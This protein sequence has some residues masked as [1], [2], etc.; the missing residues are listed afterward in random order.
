MRKLRAP[1]WSDRDYVD[2]RTQREI[3]AL[4]GMR[5]VEKGGEV[6]VKGGLGKRDGDGETEDDAES[7]KGRKGMSLSAMAVLMKYK[8]RPGITKA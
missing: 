5:R 1:A 7:D 4:R 3:E 6:I 2:Q 8:E